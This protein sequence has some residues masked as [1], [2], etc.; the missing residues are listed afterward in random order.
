LQIIGQ[1]STGKSTFL[2]YLL[3][4]DYPGNM[5]GPEPTTDKFT[6]VMHGN[7]RKILPGNAVVLDAKMP[8]RSLSKVLTIRF[9]YYSFILITAFQGYE[10]FLNIFVLSQGNFNFTTKAELNGLLK[11]NYLPSSS[12]LKSYNFDV[13]I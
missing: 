3:G 5:I 11:F 6:V 12:A 10:I 1:Y 7:E 4:E 13:P 9:I 2:K 8:F